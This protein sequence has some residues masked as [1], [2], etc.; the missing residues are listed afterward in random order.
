MKIRNNKPNI[1]F[2]GFS[3]D[4]KQYALS[5]VSYVFDGTHQTPNYTK[6]GVGFVSVENIKDLEPKKYISKE[7]YDREYAKKPAEKGDVFMTRIGNVGISKVINTEETLAYYV[8]LALLKPKD[9]DS[10]FLNY[11][12]GSSEVQ[13]DIWKRTLHI[14]FPKKINLDEINQILLM[15]P[16]MKEQKK[17][18]DFFK[19]ID[20]I[21]SL[22][23]RKL[24]NL[25]T[26]KNTFLNKLF[27][28]NNKT[29]PIFRFT[30]FNDDWEQLKLKN[31]LREKNIQHPQNEEYPLVSFT[32]E[33]GVTPKTERYEREQLVVGKK[34]HKNY[35]A[36]QFNDIVYNPANLKFGAISRNT[37]GN[38]VFSPIYTTF[39]VN[40][41][42][43]PEFVEMY[44][45]RKNFINFALKY[46]QGTVYERQAVHPNDFLKLGIK[47]PCISEQTCLAELYRE[48]NDIITLH[49]IKLEHLE[50]MKK[51][52]LNNMFI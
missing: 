47:L 39:L 15:L 2:K 35:K 34:N 36:T 4:L 33:L 27:S 51:Y 22:H 14:A 41:N 25:E 19:Q 8:T 29:I 48:I 46:Q 17:I 9:I 44:V 5:E 40:S 10:H 3:Y 26:L 1:R 20:T 23:Q 24:D 50:N 12:I 37:Y 16:K 11:V 38:A 7:A 31:V 18:G 13:K 32:A 45:T 30:G 49:Q 52:F 21:I 28:E 6:S 43:V 42:Y